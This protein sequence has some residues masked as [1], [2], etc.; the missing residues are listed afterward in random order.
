MTCSVPCIVA[1]TPRL[2][3]EWD[4]VHQR[5]SRRAVTMAHHHRVARRVLLVPSTP[6]DTLPIEDD[7]APS[8]FTLKLVRPAL[9]PPA[10]PAA[11]PPASRRHAGCR[12]PLGSANVI[13]GNRR[14]APASARGPWPHSLA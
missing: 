13:G 14:A 9:G 3:T 8:N 1:F 2:A 5:S 7:A 4:Q 10:E 6:I 12:S 11:P